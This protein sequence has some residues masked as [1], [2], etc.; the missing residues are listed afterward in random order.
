MSNK[1]DQAIVLG[2]KDAKQW[3]AFQEILRLHKAGV[4][5]TIGF[6]HCNE[7]FPVF[8]PA[9]FG[10]SDYVT[11]NFTGVPQCLHNYIRQEIEHSVQQAKR[12]A[13]LQKI[14]DEE[15]TEV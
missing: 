9:V 2:P 11:E 3:R 4:R 7:I 8:R 10:Q 14:L 5:F 6:T 12:A 13:K 15:A 1:I